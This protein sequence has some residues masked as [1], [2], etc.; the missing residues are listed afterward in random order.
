VLSKTA[1]KTKPHA[2]PGLEE[3][4]HPE[5]VDKLVAAASKIKEDG[6]RSYLALAGGDVRRVVQ[7]VALEME[8]AMSIRKTELEMDEC[9]RN[10]EAMERATFFLS[11]ID[12]SALIDQVHMECAP[13]SVHQT[14]AARSP[15]SR[16]RRLALARC[17]VPGHRPD[18]K[19]TY[20]ELMP[21]VQPVAQLA[22]VLQVRRIGIYA[23]E[24]PNVAL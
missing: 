13:G 16:A 23:L 15:E 6:A 14:A 3:V 17:R 1:E 21:A 4:L 18:G 10:A 8:E 7:D 2:Q 12:N 19:P 11:S 9:A 24:D 22:S 5:K 20:G